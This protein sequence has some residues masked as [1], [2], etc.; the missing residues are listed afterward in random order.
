MLEN[1][2][3]IQTKNWINKVVIDCNFCPFAARAVLKKT[4]HYSVQK[5]ISEKESIEVFKNEIEYLNTHL[6]LET[7]F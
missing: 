7:S 4:I 2:V 5:D 1:E 6:D 3:V